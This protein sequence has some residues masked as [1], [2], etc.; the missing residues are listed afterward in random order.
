MITPHTIEARNLAEWIDD[1]LNEMRPYA[2]SSTEDKRL[3]VSLTGRAIVYHGLT[4][5]YTSRDLAHAVQVYNSITAMP[6]E[7]P[8]VNQASLSVAVTTDATLVRSAK[9]VRTRY[10]HMEQDG[11]GCAYVTRMSIEAAHKFSESPTPTLYC[12]G[13]ARHHPSQAFV[14]E[15]SNERVSAEGDR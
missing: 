12:A 13:C 6:G 15:G 14:W 7:Q 10:R 1:E 5:V 2:S 8:P 4:A 9:P 3:L 11:S